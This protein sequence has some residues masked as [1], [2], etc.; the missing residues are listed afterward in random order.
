MS[1]S[2]NMTKSDR[3]TLIQICRMRAKVA[4]ADAASRSATLKADCEAQLAK[5]YHWDQDDV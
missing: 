4:K 1:N 3:D 2:T 5:I